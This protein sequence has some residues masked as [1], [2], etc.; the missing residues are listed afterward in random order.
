M[1]AAQILTQYLTDKYKNNLLNQYQ[2]IT[3]QYPGKA[4]M[5][6]SPVFQAGME[7]MD[8]FGI[9][10]G[11]GW[12]GHLVSQGINK[13]IPSFD[14]NAAAAAAPF[15]GGIVVPSVES[16]QK[17]YAN[18]LGEDPSSR[19]TSWADEMGKH[20]WAEA[21][22]HETSHLGWEYEPTTKYGITS[23]VWPTLEHGLGTFKADP[24]NPKY[25]GEEQ[26]NYMHD[27]TYGPRYDDEFNIPGKHYLTTRGLINKGDLSY[28]PEAFDVIANSG[29]IPEHKKAIGFGI[30]PF[31]DTRA[32]GRWYQMQQDKRATDQGIA[33]A[34]TQRRIREAEAAQAAAQQVRQN[35]QT[36]GNRDRPNTG[37]N[38]P[39]GGRGQSPTGGD[40]S[41]TPFARGGLIDLYRYGG[42]I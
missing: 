22:G 37:I 21:F 33:Q 2:D 25:G 35:I 34:A 11:I 4:D 7:K 42:F 15:G 9:G 12:L 18:L 19:A 27:L 14:T 39:G 38:R 28:T 20:N 3:T 13:V 10:S 16:F 26:W 6:T 17:D 36:Y 8:P 23:S 31:E 29:L 40:V 41:G 24:S 5:T 1:A 32:A 30:N